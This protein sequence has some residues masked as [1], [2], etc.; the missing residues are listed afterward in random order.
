[1]EW[2]LQGII[3]CG[4]E[5]LMST[6]S[7]RQGDL[8]LLAEP[9][10]IKWRLPGVVHLPPRSSIGRLAS[11]LAGYEDAIYGPPPMHKAVGLIR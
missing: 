11:R 6:I 9:F 10:P 4:G 7:R 2:T 3:L 8:R 5:R 1:M